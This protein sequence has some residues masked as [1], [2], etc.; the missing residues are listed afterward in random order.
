MG[1]VHHAWHDGWGVDVAIKHPRPVFLAN[2]E[3]IRGFMDEIE[4]WAQIGMHPN[5]VTCY[6]AKLIDGLPCAVAE[7]VDGGSLQDAI[8][9]QALYSGPEGEVLARTLTIAA[10]SAWGLAHAHANGLMH[11]DM[12]PGNILLAAAGT[13]KITDFGLSRRLAPAGEVTASA[14]L[15]PAYA[16]PEQ[17][18]SEG[19]SPATDAW[20]WAAS[21]LEIFTGGRRWNEGPVC[22]AVLD[23]F[24]QEGAKS[25]GLPAMPERLANLLR[26]CFHSKA[27]VRLSDFAAIAEEVCGAYQDIFGEPC[28]ALAP[29]RALRSAD[30]L[31]NQAVSRYDIGERGKANKLLAGALAL[32]PLHPEANYNQAIMTF[33]EAGGFHSGVF[34]RLALVARYDLGDYRPLLYSACLHLLGGDKRQANAARAR[35][36]D[37]AHGENCEMIAHL[38]AR[39]SAGFKQL[40]LAPPI[41]GEDVAYHLA[42]FDRLMEKTEAALAD[43]RLNDAQRYLLMSGD[44]PGYARHP[45]RRALLAKANHSGTP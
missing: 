20:S 16:S 28:P 24:I 1:L 27:T 4:R 17:L 43:H 11:C 30:S 3:G 21:I 31:N 32:D 15:T 18:R 23:E 22:G 38:W 45:R 41:S 2:P 33:V 39:T 13:A 25:P 34:D 36:Y 9:T 19:L 26:C 12:K 42:R 29:D 35:A 37:V 6:Y 8:G 44:I 10:G 40:V 5:V 14:G 7:Y